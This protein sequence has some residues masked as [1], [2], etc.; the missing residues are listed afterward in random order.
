M[1]EHMGNMDNLIATISD[2]RMWQA[3]AGLA[4]LTRQAKDSGCDC[5]PCVQ[6]RAIGG[7]LDDV[8]REHGAGDNPA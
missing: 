6:L 3:A 1:S 2:K 5:I 8:H 7:F 4:D